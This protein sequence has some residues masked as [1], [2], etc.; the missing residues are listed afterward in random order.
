MPL[1]VSLDVHLTLGQNIS[2]GR[3]QSFRAQGDGSSN[4]AYIV[5]NMTELTAEALFLQLCGPD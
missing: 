1:G 5:C 4:A 2:T 3:Y